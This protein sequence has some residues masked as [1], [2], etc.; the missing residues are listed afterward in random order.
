MMVRRFC[1]FLLLSLAAVP[2][3]CS[4]GRSGKVTEQM[5]PGRELEMEVGSY[6]F[7]PDRIVVSGKGTIVIVMTNVSGDKH[8]LTVENPAGGIVGGVDVG[9]GA[10]ETLRVDL[11]EPGTY[12]FYCD[13]PFHPRM[14]MTGEIVVQ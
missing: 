8:N 3:S 6:Y 12:P 7:E 5:E 10:T 9:A 11:P 4:G 13:I 14:G 1:M 2:V